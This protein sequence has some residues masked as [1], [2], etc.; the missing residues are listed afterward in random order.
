MGIAETGEW[1][2]LWLAQKVRVKILLSDITSTKTID[3]DLMEKR[4]SEICE[5]L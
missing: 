3:G 4:Q 2:F 5:N 1:K